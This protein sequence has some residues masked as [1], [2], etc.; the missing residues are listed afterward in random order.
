MKRIVSLSIS[1]FVVVA[2]L[3]SCTAIP[4]FEIDIIQFD[5]TSTGLFAGATITF[6][7]SI[8]NGDSYNWDFGDG[9]TGVG[10]VTS[11]SY[12]SEGTFT[13]RLEITTGSR[14]LVGT[15]A[16]VI[17]L[18]SAEVTGQIQQSLIDSLE[19]DPVFGL[20]PDLIKV[21]P[22]VYA[23]A[24]TG[25]LGPGYVS[26]FFLQDDGSLANSLIDTFNFDADF[27]FPVKIIEVG[28]GVYAIA[29]TGVDEHGQV[30]T[31][32]IDANGNIGGSTIDSLE[33]LADQTFI[34]D[35]IQVGPSTYAIAYT[36]P[37]R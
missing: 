25:D 23:V 34:T 24:Y 19:F 18:G 11:H 35:L 29:Y 20:E 30:V 3:T 28:P 36:G 4:L 10:Q 8:N 12:S 2:A 37:I 17:R 13:V 27:A 26:T 33:F 21:G 16:I 22:G 31:V 32:S 15:K 6:R 5:T 7:S 14:K 9:S 1:I